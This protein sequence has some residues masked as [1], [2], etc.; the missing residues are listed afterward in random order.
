MRDTR[1]DKSSA[2]KVAGAIAANS[3]GSSINWSGNV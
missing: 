3:N 1:L 2:L